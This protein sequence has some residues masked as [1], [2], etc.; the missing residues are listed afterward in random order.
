[1]TATT[2]RLVR[3]LDDIVRKSLYRRDD[4]SHAAG[5]QRGSMAVAGHQG[6]RA[7]EWRGS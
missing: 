3:A 7:R 2:V 6:S 5:L 1:M 4:L